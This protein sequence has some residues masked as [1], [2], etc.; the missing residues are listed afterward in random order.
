MFGNAADAFN[1]KSCRKKRYFK[2]TEIIVPE[3]INMNFWFCA[4]TC[5]ETAGDLLFN[6]FY[7]LNFTL[8]DPGLVAFHVENIILFKAIESNPNF[9]CSERILCTLISSVLL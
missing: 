1:Y 9:S 2:C 4:I 5:L 7:F 3:A 6:W 8:Y